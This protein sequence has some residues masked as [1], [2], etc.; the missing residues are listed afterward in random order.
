MSHSDIIGPIRYWSKTYPELAELRFDA[1]LLRAAPEHRTYIEAM[2][3]VA[4][5]RTSG[6]GLGTSG[7]AAGSIDINHDTWRFE[8]G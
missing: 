3:I 5:C 1:A 7:K 2:K 6:S 4:A 8:Y